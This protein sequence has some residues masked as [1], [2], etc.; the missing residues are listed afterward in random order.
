M[1]KTEREMQNVIS[2]SLC[3]NNAEIAKT[4]LSRRM[5]WHR[6]ERTLW[7]SG[8]MVTPAGR[9]KAVQLKTVPVFTR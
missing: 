6:Q 5:A 3:T 8:V 9:S 4:P 2:K 7:K 1:E